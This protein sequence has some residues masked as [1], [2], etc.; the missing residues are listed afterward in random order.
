MEAQDEIMWEWGLVCKGTSLK[1]E[2]AQ[3]RALLYHLLSETHKSL[4]GEH[5]SV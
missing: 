5:E 2:S 1:G 4:M 3:P